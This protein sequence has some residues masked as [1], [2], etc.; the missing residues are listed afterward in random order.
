MLHSLL[1]RGFKSHCVLVVAFFLLFYWYSFLLAFMVH[2][3]YILSSIMWCI[4]FWFLSKSNQTWFAI[5]TNFVQF[6]CLPWCGELAASAA[7]VTCNGATAS[8]SE[9]NTAVMKKQVKKIPMLSAWLAFSVVVTRTIQPECKRRPPTAECK[10]IFV[11]WPYPIQFSSYV[12]D[13]RIQLDT[14]QKS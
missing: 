7:V 9:C 2:N 5:A 14:Y 12:S 3:I 8:E 1:D 13:T 10:A 6:K 4:F 11:C